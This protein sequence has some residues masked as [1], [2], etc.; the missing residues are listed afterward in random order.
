MNYRL[1]I[2]YD[3]TD[4]HGWQ[5]QENDR[6]I[7]GELERVIGMLADTDVLIDFMAGVEP[8]KSA[9]AAYA[10]SGRL[11]TSAISCF[12]LLSG[13]RKGH[14]GDQV[15]RLVSLLTIVPLDRAA[16][17]RAAEVRLRL[18]EGGNPIGMGDSLIAGIALANGLPLL[19]RNRKHFT[20]VEGLVLRDFDGAVH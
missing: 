8:A 7:Q 18:E 1:L 12:E 20:R 5:V 14:R 11:Q 15:R 9:V 19:T 3:G 10:S 17:I 2:Q 4:F 16:A 6:T 13:A